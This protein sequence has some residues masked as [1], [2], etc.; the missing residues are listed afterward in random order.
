MRIVGNKKALVSYCFTHYC[1]TE[2]EE[3]R[4]ALVVLCVCCVGADC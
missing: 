3:S 2:N 4:F 1:T